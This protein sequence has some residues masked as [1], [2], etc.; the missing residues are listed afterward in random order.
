MCNSQRINLS[1]HIVVL[2]MNENKYFSQLQYIWQIESLVQ[3]KNPSNNNKTFLKAPLK[4]NLCA[5]EWFCS[6]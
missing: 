6:I 4:C 5:F 2:N 3:L 1:K